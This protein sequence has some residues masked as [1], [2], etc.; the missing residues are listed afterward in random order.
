MKRNQLT[1][2]IEND[3]LLLKKL[4]SLERTFILSVDAAEKVKLSEEIGEVKALIEQLESDEENTECRV[5]DIII[6]LTRISYGLDVLIEL[7]TK[8]EE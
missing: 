1:E 7:K 4:A 5:H 6:L 3:R 2:F 8:G